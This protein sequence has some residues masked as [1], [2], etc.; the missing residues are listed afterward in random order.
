MEEDF[1]GEFEPVRQ[2][3]DED[4]RNDKLVKQI[5]WQ[6]RMRQEAKAAMAASAAG[7]DSTAPAANLQTIT[8]GQPKRPEADVADRVLDTRKRPKLSKPPKL[9]HA[10]RFLQKFQ[11]T[12]T[13]PPAIA[14]Q[15]EKQKVNG[16]QEN[17]DV[18]AEPNT[19]VH[20]GDERVTPT[21]RPQ[22]AAS[23][24]P[25]VAAAKVPL[26]SDDV[27]GVEAAK[28]AA[29]EEIGATGE[30]SNSETLY[31]NAGE[32]DATE[33][34]APAV[35][36]LIAA[37]PLDDV[38]DADTDLETLPAPLLPPT[39]CALSPPDDFVTI[40]AAI[41]AQLSTTTFPNLPLSSIADK[42]HEVFCMFQHTV[43]DH[44]GHLALLIGP[45]ALGKT[46]II[47][48]AL[49][50][51]QRQYADT[52]I[53]IRLNAY[54][55]PDENTALREIARQ[56]DQSLRRV[57]A[58]SSQ[59]AQFEQRSLSD[60]FANI[61]ATLDTTE[62]GEQ[63]DALRISVIFVVEE[64]EKFTVG[65]QTLLYNLFDLAHS[66]STPVCVM[67]VSLKITVRE[68]L[69]KRVR[70]R[71]SQRVIAINRPRTVSEFWANAKLGLMVPGEVSSQLQD[72]QL[73]EAWNGSI[74][75][76]YADHHGALR[77]LVLSI[78]YTTKNYRDFN[79][80][81]VYAV[82][83]ADPLPQ[84]GDYALYSQHQSLGT[85]E[86][87][88]RSLLELELLLLIAAARWVT[89]LALDVTNFNLAYREYEEMIKQLNVAATASADA[90]AGFKVQ[91]RVRLPTIL[92]NSWQNLYKLEM[93]L[94]PNPE[95]ATAGYNFG[96]IEESHMVHLD[97][98]LEELG[99][100]VVEGNIAHKLTR[101]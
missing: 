94:E 55:Q 4:A 61:L 69:E 36:T 1:S 19:E 26:A 40:R 101:L 10:L 90:M 92:R 47:Q 33:A 9:A 17:Q 81:V 60:T 35:A 80:N 7:I 52:F 63:T 23:V 67:G 54:H 57:R 13:R 39:D 100:I 29:N 8:S 71:F 86:A 82:S 15:Q 75:A 50:E 30:T 43:R 32:A 93:L 58:D 84:Q 37:S 2:V 12:L 88:T 21:Y 45:R 96:V 59:A 6:R 5:M 68:M 65:K 83:R 66:A 38:A 72:P 78:F 24:A 62:R 91:Q 28:G 79:N 76:A 41:M 97:I 16:L 99:Q 51:L 48:R 64:F 22:D 85:T 53:V 42:Y 95:R 77:N 27:I 14:P 74:E 3:S 34:A 25:S 73:A 87:V 56:L 98:T 70:L 18:D 46:A 11:S 31:E 20:E 89:K 49:A 44:E